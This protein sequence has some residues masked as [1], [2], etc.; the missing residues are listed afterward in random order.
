MWHY[1]RDAAPNWRR[2]A[3]RIASALL[4][5]FALATFMLMRYDGSKSHVADY[6]DQSDT[7]PLAG[8]QLAV[9]QQ[10]DAQTVMASGTA[11]LRSAPR[12]CQTETAD[13]G[14]TNLPSGLPH[15]QASI[16]HFPSALPAPVI[17]HTA[18]VEAGQLNNTHWH[19]QHP[20]PPLLIET[21]S[22]RRMFSDRGFAAV[23]DESSFLEHATGPD[24]VRASA[25]NDH[26]FTGWFSNS[27]DRSEPRFMD[28]SLPFAREVLRTALN[29]TWIHVS[30]CS[31]GRLLSASLSTLLQQ[32][33]GMQTPP[34]YVEK[35]REVCFQKY[36]PLV[37][38]HDQH[39]RLYA[40]EL[41]DCRT[42]GSATPIDIVADDVE[43]ADMSRE[44]AIALLRQPP[45]QSG[46][47]ATAENYADRL[48]S[49]SRSE[50]APQEGTDRRTCPSVS[51]GNGFPE[52]RLRRGRLAILTSYKW[53]ERTFDDPNDVDP[54]GALMRDL[55]VT[56]MPDV[57][58]ANAGIHAFHDLAL[59]NVGLGGSSVPPA[60]LAICFRNL[61][62]FADA[63]KA[64]P[65][66]AT[67]VID[68][69][70]FH[71]R[72]PS[73]RS[74]VTAKPCFVWKGM[75]D[76]GTVPVGRESLEFTRMLSRV[77]MEIL[78][79]DYDAVI[80][81]PTPLTERNAVMDRFHHDK[82]VHQL[83][84]E[85]ALNGI[86]HTCL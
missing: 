33:L 6:V 17:A 77:M 43:F 59:P 72:W 12:P 70:G 27:S 34:Q 16:T 23:I 3:A 22:A 7:V 40:K 28:R 53:K 32:V 55:N 75:N 41:C 5:V 20:P 63:V 62:R 36:S 80:L 46:L 9:V 24:R 25:R 14:S 21:E 47:D 39:V 45:S 13:I 44:E 18:D 71:H 10:V 19:A 66:S 79:K 26:Y 81:D 4:F 60:E 50:T 82:W 78:A 37:S 35:E 68:P 84:A 74:D 61:T 48:C 15:I 29:G 30:G 52:I 8:A 83:V 86:V 42:N 85:M 73:V 2:R 65:Q 1:D 54:I 49:I 58:I 57:Y 67:A 56:R 31:T 76:Y 64:G 51:S 11:A 69:R 38:L